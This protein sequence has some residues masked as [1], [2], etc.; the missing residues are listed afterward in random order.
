MKSIL[1]KNSYSRDLVDK[2]IKYFLDK[3]LAPK[4]IVSTV[5][6]KDFVIVLPY[7]GKLSLQISTRG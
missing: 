2:W 7:L 5:P 1:Y 3:I 4:T 6:K